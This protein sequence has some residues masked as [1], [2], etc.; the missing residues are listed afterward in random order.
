MKVAVFGLGYVGTVTSAC[1]ASRGHDVWGIDV[2]GTKVD[3]VAAG[4]S[5]VVEPGLGELVA[6][7][8][9]RGSLHATTSAREAMEGAAVSLVCVG[10]PSSP[11]GGTDLGFV[12]RAV[13]DIGDALRRAPSA[14]ASPPFH[15]VVVRS[16]VPPGT[17]Q[18]VVAPALEDKL[19]VEEGFVFGTAMCPEFLREG[20]GVADFFD[21]PFT[22]VGTRHTRLADTLVELFH[23]LPDPVRIV[24][25]SSA[26][27][28]KY[29]CNAFHANKVA[30]TNE[31]ARLFRVFGID[32]REVMELFCQDEHLNISS[33]Y[34]RPGFAFG[35]P[36]L[37]KDLR[38]L[39]HLGRMHS[40][41]M[42][43][44]SGII[45]SNDRVVSDVIDRVATEEGRNVALLGLSFKASSDDLRESP[46]VE[47]AETLVGKGFTVRIYDPVVNPSH[48]VG[49]NL[50][51]IESKL[52]H[53][54]RFL[55][56]SATEALADADV[57]IAFSSD[58][59]I[60]DG[61]L[62]TPPRRILDLSGRLGASVEALAGYEGMGW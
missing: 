27:A 3:M 10:T 37:P 5:P 52:P 47:V 41:D 50:Q 23:F 32:S 62:T 14:G 29:A 15:S 18:G 46:N 8:A 59:A 56:D 61:L 24:G 36:C 7:A 21:P 34:L 57:A 44:L 19:G 42:P 54:R 55:A 4:K 22:V 17:V 1:L 51:F 35:G 2:D 9:A 25:T 39:L 11:T 33:T 38:S 6:H 48:L 28:L 40:V 30:F 53:L 26:E 20:S 45:S 58:P 60:V 49:A 43:L 12:L 16:T 13:D 31:L